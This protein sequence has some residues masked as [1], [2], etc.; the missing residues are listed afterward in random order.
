MA[1]WKIIYQ[2]TPFNFTTPAALVIKADDVEQALAT[3]YDHLTRCGKAVGK[4]VPE[5]GLRSN[6]YWDQIPEHVD[7][8]KLKAML[9]PNVDPMCM[10]GNTHIRACQ[11]Y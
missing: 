9:G 1:E 4:I 7:L 11:L 10:P 6:P 5:R 2:D 8:E 3:A